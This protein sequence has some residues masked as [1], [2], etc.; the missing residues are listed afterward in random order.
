MIPSLLL[1]P[2]ARIWDVRFE[3][4]PIG[5]FNVHGH[6]ALSLEVLYANDLLFDKFECSFN[7]DG[8][9]IMT[10]SYQN[11][12]NLLSTDGSQPN[13]LLEASRRPYRQASPQ[14]WPYHGE[15]PRDF[16]RR[17]LH[18]SFHPRQ[19]LVAIAATNALYILNA[20]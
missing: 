6:H 12:L 15:L 5:T 18:A 7:H 2:Q 14:A 10:G 19:N 3:S 8:T 17:I 16:S 20:T 11:R 13:E 4:A 9:Q 1:A